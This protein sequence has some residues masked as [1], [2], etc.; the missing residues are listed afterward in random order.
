MTDKTREE[1]AKL[2]LCKDWPSCTRKEK[3]G[4][5]FCVNNND[6][7]D[8]KNCSECSADAILAIPQIEEG[9]KLR[10]KRDRLVE[11]VSQN[12]VFSSY[13]FAYGPMTIKRLASGESR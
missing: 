3:W 11:L 13:G 8:E 12:T 9:R 7:N 10:E 6:P 4:K 1:I 5:Y 2:I